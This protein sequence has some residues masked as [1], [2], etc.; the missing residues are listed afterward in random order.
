MGCKDI[1]IRKSVFVTKTQFLNVFKIVSW[2]RIKSETL[3]HGNGSKKRKPNK[4]VIIEICLCLKLFKPA[5]C[6]VVDFKIYVSSIWTVL[7]KI[8][9]VW[10]LKG[11][12]HQVEKYIG[13]RKFEFVAKT[14]FLWIFKIVTWKQIKK[15]TNCNKKAE[16]PQ[17]TPCLMRFCVHN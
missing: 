10:N 14:Q 11:L 3:Q 2:K 5:G 13:I 9:W 4:N 15:G 8:D 16:L 1:E 6:N 12:P 7:D 17:K